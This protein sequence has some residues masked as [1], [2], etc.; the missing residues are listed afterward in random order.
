MEVYTDQPGVQFYT[1]NFIS[2]TI[3]V[4]GKDGAEYVKHGALALETQTWPDAV[5]NVRLHK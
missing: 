5:N 4:I 3:P 2:D 1:S